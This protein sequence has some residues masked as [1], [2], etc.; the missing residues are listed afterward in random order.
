M[1]EQDAKLNNGATASAVASIL[2]GKSIPRRKDDGQ[3]NTGSAGSGND[4]GN[5]RATREAGGFDELPDEDTDTGTDTGTDTEASTVEQEGQEEKPLTLKELAK[6]LGVDAK[7]LYEVEIPIGDGK[8]L[9]LGELKD[10]A[11]QSDDHRTALEQLRGV[12]TDRSNE[13]MLARRE[14]ATMMQA[15]GDQVDPMAVHA[16]QE[17]NSKHLQRETTLM[18][19][20]IPEWRDPVHR[21]ADKKE[22]VD[23]VGK[24]GFTE[25]ELGQ[26]TDHRL[27]KLL[28]DMAKGHAAASAAK[29][30]AQKPPKHNA[31]SPASKSPSDNLRTL[32]QRAK[33]PGSRPSDKAAAIGALLK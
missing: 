15:L 9:S 26:V 20:A 33:A 23:F 25:S 19:A 13:V 28:R 27:V 12:E 1:P 5:D 17:M 6:E 2:E 30:Q 4:P 29:Q 3:R 18:M 10:L 32:L 11:K 22:M 16:V 14:L 31:P 7:S 21:A 24:Y 8:K